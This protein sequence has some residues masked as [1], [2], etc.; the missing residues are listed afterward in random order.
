MQA[1]AVRI[2][3]AIRQWFVEHRGSR[4]LMRR[5]VDD[6]PFRRHAPPMRTEVDAYHRMTPNAAKFRKRHDKR[7]RCLRALQAC[8][9]RRG[10]VSGYPMGVLI[11]AHVG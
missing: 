3:C 6:A 7:Q 11:G 1:P 2:F 9:F 4:P 5:W 8:G 10:I